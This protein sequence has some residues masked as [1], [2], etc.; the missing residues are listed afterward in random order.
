MLD[1]TQKV[2]KNELAALHN[3]EGQLT[4][5]LT[6]HQITVDKLTQELFES[7]EKVSCLEISYRTLK[8]ER[9][10]LY[11]GERRARQ[12]YEDII[13]EQRSRNILLTNLQTIQNN[14]ERNEYETK[15][16][17]TTQIEGLEKENTLLKDRLHGEDERR[18]KMRDAYE[19]Q[20]SKKHY[21]IMLPFN[22]Y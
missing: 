2:F 8:S 3:K 9:D 11:E 1:S 6:K 14:L 15:Q 10:M 22:Y 16:R 18:N 19:T 7:K 20:V 12:Q 5:A 17:L 13:R 4:S 21:I